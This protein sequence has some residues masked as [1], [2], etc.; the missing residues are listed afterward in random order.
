MESS[1]ILKGNHS[2]TVLLD[3]PLHVDA[4]TDESKL[5]GHSTWRDSSPKTAILTTLPPHCL[6][7]WTTWKL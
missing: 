7:L 2:H 1:A 5:P 4:V 3:T 6:Q